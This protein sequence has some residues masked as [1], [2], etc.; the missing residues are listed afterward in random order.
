M[1]HLHQLRR[2][3]EVFYEFIIRQLY[4]VSGD[5]LGH[6]KIQRKL[7]KNFLS[8]LDFFLMIKQ[9]KHSY[10]SPKIFYILEMP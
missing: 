2:C 3:S 6:L 4:L 1:K 5:D 7:Q 10:F 9:K 8:Q